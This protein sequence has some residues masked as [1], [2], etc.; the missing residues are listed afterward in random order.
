MPSIRT[1]IDLR[2]DRRY[3]VDVGGVLQV[4]GLATNVYVVRVI[5]IS[6]SGL[7]VSCPIS[8]SVGSRVEVTSC[9]TS[10]VGEV[11]YTREVDVS[12]FWL[13]IRAD[14]ATD[15]GL[16]LTAFLQPIARYL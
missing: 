2:A 1:P 12:E 8:V 9:H 16:D 13:G 3:L 11:R 5:N 10:I 4:E 15:G 14:K 6:R 7:R